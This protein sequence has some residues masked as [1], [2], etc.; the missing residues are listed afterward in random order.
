MFGVGVL[1]GGFRGGGFAVGVLGSGFWARGFRL[2][3]LDGKTQDVAR[4]EVLGEEGPRLYIPRIGAGYTIS[5]VR[6]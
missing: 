5:R 6:R 1:G 3:V 2:G 4:R